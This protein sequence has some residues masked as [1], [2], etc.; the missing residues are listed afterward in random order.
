VADI[1][2]QATR[3]R[4]MAGIRNKNT[5]PE[6]Q[7]RNALHANGFRYRLHASNVPGQ[8]DATFPRYRATLF[9]NGCFWHGHDCHLFRLPG[10][11]VEFWREKIARNRQRDEKVRQQ[12]REKGWRTLTIWECAIKG[13]DSIGLPRVVSEASTW[14]RSSSDALTIRGVA[15][16]AR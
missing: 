9:V 6:I 4:M 16:G 10:T 1:V 5:R 11:R 7:I 14:L 2:D 3:S 12:L 8:P 15:H 13:R